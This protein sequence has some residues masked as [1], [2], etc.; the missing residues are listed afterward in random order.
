[1]YLWS[2]IIF[3]IEGELAWKD[4]DHMLQVLLNSDVDLHVGLARRALQAE[5]VVIAKSAF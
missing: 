2:V 3:A 1:M 4:A 5:L